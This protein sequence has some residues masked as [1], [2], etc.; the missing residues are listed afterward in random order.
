MIAKLLNLTREQTNLPIIGIGAN[1]F[2]SSLSILRRIIRERIYLNI[3][4]VY[5]SAFFIN[6]E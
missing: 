4:V 1:R 6:Y 3:R 2:N 5:S